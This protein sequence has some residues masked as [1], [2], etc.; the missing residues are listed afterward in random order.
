MANINSNKYSYIPFNKK[1]SGTESSSESNSTESSSESSSTESSTSEKSSA[2]IK[3]SKENVEE[4]GNTSK[5]EE[6]NS[7]LQAKLAQLKEVEKTKKKMEKTKKEVEEPTKKICDEMESLKKKGYKDID[8]GQGN[9]LILAS[10]SN[11]FYIQDH[12]AYKGKGKGGVSISRGHG[13]G[14]LLINGLAAATFG[15]ETLKATDKF[16]SAL[17]KNSSKEEIKTAYEELKSSG[18][19]QLKETFQEASKTKRLSDQA[20]YYRSEEYTFGKITQENQEIIYIK[21]RLPEYNKPEGT[22]LSFNLTTQEFLKNGE[23][24][25]ASTLQDLRVVLSELTPRAIQM[26][27]RVGL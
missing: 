13:L 14:T 9:R 26:S 7:V 6:T 22:I 27:E 2:S 21:N 8:L 4:Q 24:K 10:G 3:S 5:E 12:E 16:V 23:K 1:S 25:D 20:A 11:S 15:K 19:Q 18:N 17:S